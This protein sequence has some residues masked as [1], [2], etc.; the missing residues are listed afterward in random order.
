M[1]GLFPSK[2]DQLGMRFIV[3]ADISVRHSSWV[4]SPTIEY[5][6]P[7]SKRAYIGMSVSVNVYG[8]GFGAYY[9]DV[10]PLGSAASGLPVYERAGR[11][12]TADRKST[13]L[14]SSH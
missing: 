14:N 2:Y 13:R 7:L 12:A 10:D 6:T 9:F 4:A 5:S 8:K 11:K 1:P 3:L